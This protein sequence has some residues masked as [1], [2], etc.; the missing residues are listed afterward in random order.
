MVFQP[1][2]RHANRAVQSVLEWYEYD[3]QKAS[4]KLYILRGQPEG[5]H[6]RLPL[7]R[8]EAITATNT[9]AQVTITEP[10]SAVSAFEAFFYCIKSKFI[11]S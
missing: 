4:N 9:A 1:D 3:K 5:C 10:N 2:K 6:S 11:I 8:Y 7:C